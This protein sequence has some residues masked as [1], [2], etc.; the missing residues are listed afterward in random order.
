MASTSTFKTPASR[1]L[2]WTVAGTL[3]LAGQAQGHGLMQDPP[4][5]NWFCGAVTKP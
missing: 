3:G 5:R 2:A 1:L 4:A